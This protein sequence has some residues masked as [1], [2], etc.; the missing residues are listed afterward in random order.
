MHL[1]PPEST[2][3]EMGSCKRGCP[4]AAWVVPT[5]MAS[6]TLQPPAQLH[7]C[8]PLRSLLYLRSAPCH[9]H[10]HV[11]HLS[12]ALD[13]VLC[14]VLKESSCHTYQLSL[15]L[16]DR[17]CFFNKNSQ[18]Y[19]QKICFKALIWSMPAVAFSSRPRH[20][21]FQSCENSQPILCFCFSLG[22]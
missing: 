5:S 1:P 11:H 15:S 9:F 6:A 12:P 2:R 22:I 7:Y 3:Y 4:M 13:F 19:S 20:H 18:R 10:F 8:I 21:F 16:S 14:S 17:S